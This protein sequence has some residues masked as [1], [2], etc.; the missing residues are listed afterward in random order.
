MTERLLSTCQDRERHA[1]IFLSL[2]WLQAAFVRPSFFTLF[3]LFELM[4]CLN[5]RSL[6]LAVP[7]YLLMFELLLDWDL[8][9]P[10]V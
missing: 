3:A 1:Q 10:V 4:F 9:L 8:S 7:L 6:I 2:C 5:K